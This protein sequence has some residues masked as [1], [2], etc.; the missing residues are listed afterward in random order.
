MDNDNVMANRNFS[1]S[2]CDTVGHRP[3]VQVHKVGNP[4]HKERGFDSGY[5][6]NCDS[7][8]F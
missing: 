6:D 5:V 4:Q 2:D 7:S 1:G 3:T 8:D